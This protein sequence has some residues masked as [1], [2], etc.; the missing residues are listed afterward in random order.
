MKKLTITCMIT[1]LL[2]LAGCVNSIQT[3]TISDNISTNNI[4]TINAENTEN[5]ENVEILLE[6]KEI[7]E[8]RIFSSLGFSVETDLENIL[9]YQNS[10][11]DFSDI[12]D[13]ICDMFIGNSNDNLSLS[14]T[15]NY[16]L[17]RYTLATA[18]SLYGLQ[19][20]DVSDYN[21]EEIREYITNHMKN[22][23]SISTNDIKVSE[24]DVK[25]TVISLD[26]SN[27]DEY[28]GEDAPSL[29]QTEIFTIKYP[30]KDEFYD[31]IYDGITNSEPF[32]TLLDIEKISKSLEY[33]IDMSKTN[34]KGEKSFKCVSFSSFYNPEYFKAPLSPEHL[35]IYFDILYETFLE[36]NLQTENLCL[37]VENSAFS[38]KSNLEI[39][40]EEYTINDK[41][42][43]IYKL[44]DL[45]L[46]I[47]YFTDEIIDNTTWITLKN[48][49]YNYD[50]EDYKNISDSDI[51]IINE[52]F[53]TI[54]ENYE[55]DYSSTTKYYLEMD[56]SIN[57]SFSDNQN[58]TYVDDTIT[59]EDG[60]LM[61]GTTVTGYVG[62]EIH[63]IIPDGVEIIGR[64]AF[65]GNE[66]IESI[67]LSDTVT[68]VSDSAFMQCPALKEITISDSVTKI[69][70]YGFAYCTNVE[71][72]NMGNSIESIGDLGF[73]GSWSVKEINFPDTLKSIGDTAFSSSH[74]LTNLVIPD[75]VTHIG[76]NAF[77]S[78][79][80]IKTVTLSNSLT[81]IPDRLFRNCKNLE[82][83]VIP[84]SVT[85]IGENAF[86]NCENLT[87]VIIQ[88]PNITIHQ[89][90]FSNCNK[91][92]LIS[93]EK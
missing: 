65:K 1:C 57:Q 17:S 77:A 51:Q 19:Y 15:H 90:A 7:S 47:S 43:G 75:S 27:L 62:D 86:L 50:I 93:F 70:Q 81:K 45:I 21:E 41:T 34:E 11:C 3:T 31:V 29:M 4:Q 24:N 8:N 63:I 67:T 87:E 5:T 54:M 84:S 91:D 22:V 40:T 76:S 72:I 35:T 68:T 64:E 33:H 80:T 46:G 61:R 74:A 18:L 53:N 42:F 10:D 89:D 32:D 82:R 55:V 83:I 60:F 16:I 78:S 38:Y 6:P 88:N 49:K 2:T 69:E 85:E 44:D 26:V 66:V 12:Y 14:D 13:N 36:L 56:L 73:N 52:I 23:L 48:T 9:F 20:D 71:V 92:L 30:D 37:Y 79:T 59:T 28:F 39:F 58:S 25:H